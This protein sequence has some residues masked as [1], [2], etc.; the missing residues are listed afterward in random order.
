MLNF[1]CS[2]NLHLNRQSIWWNFPLD[3][4]ITFA[5]WSMPEHTGVSD[6]LDLLV[7]A[8]RP[9]SGKSYITVSSYGAGE[10]ALTLAAHGSDTVFAY[11]IEDSRMLRRLIY[12]KI[13]A[14]RILGHRDYLILMGLRPAL[15]SERVILFENVLNA[16]TG[17]MHAFWVKR[18]H[19][20]GTGLYFSNQ[21]TFFLQLLW[22]ILC[23]LTSS[24]VRKEILFNASAEERRNLFRR[25]VTRPWLTRI[26]YILGSRINLFYPD[27][28]WKNSE[29]SRMYNSDPFPYF[30]HLVGAGLID[31]P[32]FAQYFQDQY[33]GMADELIPPHMRA[34][35][36]PGFSAIGQRVKVLESK[37]SAMPHIEL[38]SDTCDGAYLS[39][40][41]DYLNHEERLLLLGNISDA[42]R[43]GAT[44]LIYSND[45]FSKVPAKCGLELDV[46]ASKSLR[47]MDRVRTY[48]GVNL[49]RKA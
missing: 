36:Y 15:K 49:Y 20:V 2:F 4:W 40:V 31:N 48:S 33:L 35:R 43:P 32:L 44:A 28:L 3:L 23:V 13:A 14:A 8:L 27:R 29:Y 34:E 39:N 30:E 12:F 1:D 45:A 5:G 42:L 11:D 37:S 25:H 16:L 41:V 46:S 19:W 10:A 26:F 17:D 6:D 18:R 24:V 47:E 22:G 7:A 38:D 9:G 21:Q